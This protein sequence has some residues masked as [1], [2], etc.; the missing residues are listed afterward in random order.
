MRRA[1]AVENVNTMTI[2]TT[3]GQA[4]GTEQRHIVAA[5]LTVILPAVDVFSPFNYLTDLANIIEVE[6]ALAGNQSV[7]AT[8][9][10]MHIQ[11]QT[12]AAII[13][14]EIRE[15]ANDNLTA[16]QDMLGVELVKRITNGL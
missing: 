15:M 5:Q 3:N 11:R 14:K 7:I 1:L 8:G 4:I 9:I 16:V 13:L 12:P 10:K 6:K 2:T